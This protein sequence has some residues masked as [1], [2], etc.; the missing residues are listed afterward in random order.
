MKAA[1]VH[2]SIMLDF[3]RFTMG[4]EKYKWSSED[5]DDNDNRE[6]ETFHLAGG[7]DYGPFAIDVSVV[8]FIYYG[9]R[10]ED[11]FHQ[12]DML[13]NRGSI[14]YHN[15]HFKA[16]LHYGF[17][18]DSKPPLIPL[19][20]DVSE[21]E[22]A[23]IEAYNEKLRKKPNFYADFLYYRFNLDLFNFGKLR[24]TYSL[25]YRSLDFIRKKDGDGLGEF[26][27]ASQSLTNVLYLSYPINTDLKLSGYVSLEQVEKKYGTS[28]LDDSSSHTYPKGG[29]SLA[30][31]F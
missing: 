2:F 29:L 21:A 12:D 10:H 18:D 9:V 24:P 25:I 1:Y 28:K 31:L 3:S 15:R 22:R 26:V 19:P 14:S 4:S 8:D 11:Q 16:E 20:D 13:L 7:F 23:Y 30:L 6:N 27:Y 17:G 5:L